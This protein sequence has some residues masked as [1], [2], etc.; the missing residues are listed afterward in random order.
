M[1]Q[2]EFTL[3]ADRD[4]ARLDAKIRRRI[5]KR[6]E[7]LGQNAEQAQHTRLKGGLSDLFKFYVG[8]YRVLY[9][10][11]HTEKLLRVYRVR[12]RSE[13]YKEK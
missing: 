7:W 12:H 1:F 8:D 3:D 13:V 6:V 4:V 10:I 2:V 5:L 9:K 11:L